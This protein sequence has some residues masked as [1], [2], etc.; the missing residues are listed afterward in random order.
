MNDIVFAGKTAKAEGADK[1]LRII[2]PET[3]G[4]LVFSG[5][6]LK[7]GAGDFIVIP[8]MFACS[9]TKAGGIE[10][11][12]ERAF[13]PY[14]DARVFKDINGA[15]E[16]SA[17]QVVNYID[18]DCPAILSALGNLAVSFATDFE[19]NKNLS[20]VV[21]SVK[22]EIERR[23]SDATYSLEDSLNMLPLNY[24]YI[25]KL[26]KKE[27]GITPHEYLVSK[28]MELAKNIILSKAANRYSNYTV[29]QIAEACGFS[30]PLYFSRVF[31]K[32]YGVSPSEYGK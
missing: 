27:T 14:R 8:P 3:C 25:R 10:L 22:A 26:F 12:I 15:V 11:K 31:K 28:R 18:K 20:P 24:D 23:L 30:E 9:L 4:E 2:V 29:S 7:Y 13:L 16:F 19:K 1:Y 17:A 6:S 5:G 32:Y 21:A